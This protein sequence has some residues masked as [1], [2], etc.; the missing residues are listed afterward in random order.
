MFGKKQ[1]VFDDFIAAA[2]FL[3]SNKYTS[4]SEFAIFGSNSGLLVGSAMTQRPDLFQAVVCAYPL[5]DMLR[6]Q[7]FLAALI[8]LRSM[9]ARKT[10]ISFPIFTPTRHLARSSQGTKYPATIFMTGDG[11]TRVAPLHAR[12]IAALLQANS[13]IG[14]PILLFHDTKSGHSGGRPS[15]KSSKNKPTS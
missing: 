8:G 12:K 11:N 4:P 2:E 3:V 7:K 10:P 14:K 15:T 6:F 13:R 1:G 5:L 9:A